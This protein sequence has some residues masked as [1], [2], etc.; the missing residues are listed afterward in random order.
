[1]PRFRRSFG[2]LVAV[3]LCALLVGP[4]N[5]RGPRRI[6]RPEECDPLT[7]QGVA[8]WTGSG[9]SIDLDVTV[10]LDGVPKPEAQAIFDQAADSYAALDIELLPTFRKVI[11][12]PDTLR[13][14]TLIA[15]ARTLSGNARPEGADVVYILTNRDITIASGDAVGY[16]DCIG[17]IRYPNR[18]FAI[19]ES[20]DEPLGM[21][22]LNFY[23]D[24]PAKTAAHEIGHLLGARHEHANCA[25]GAGANDA[26]GREP[27]V[28]T[29]MTNYLDFQSRNFGSIEAVV[30]RSY[31]EAYGS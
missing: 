15:E 23:I 8:A 27:T 29:L 16:S 24:G 31:A 7:P 10:L 17:G 22:G 11:L 20:I 26:I 19:G 18:A 4:A 25:E 2:V 5:A 30:I 6:D 1:M 28:C 9:S 14:E 21:A 3:G 12:S 13:A